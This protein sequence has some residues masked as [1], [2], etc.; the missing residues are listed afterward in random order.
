M[1]RPPGRAEA[2]SVA[3]TVSSDHPE[4]VNVARSLVFHGQA[5]NVGVLYDQAFAVMTPEMQDRMGGLETWRSGLGS[6]FWRSLDI[7]DVRASGPD[8]IA[9]VRLRTVQ[10]AQHGPAGQTCSDWKL[11]STSCSGMIRS[12]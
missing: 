8:L 9:A 11:W 7:A 4:A 10:D 1:P 6:S 3:V 12:G 2:G 5:I